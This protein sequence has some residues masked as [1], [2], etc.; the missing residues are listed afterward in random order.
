MPLQSLNKSVSIFLVF[1]CMILSAISGGIGFYLGK[2]S[3]AVQYER[4]LRTL[5]E[6]YIKDLRDQ[7]A[8]YGRK[9]EEERNRAVLA[10][11][12]RYEMSSR[13]QEII[14]E[15]VASGT[16]CVGDNAYRLQLEELYKAYGYGE[17]T[18]DID[19]NGVYDVLPE[20]ATD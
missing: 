15:A 10:E 7:Q 12:K 8:A 3:V 4:Q 13:A 20:A 16:D 1:L 9:V 18:A 17:T 5:Q 19:A 2:N 6:A 14:N 11:A